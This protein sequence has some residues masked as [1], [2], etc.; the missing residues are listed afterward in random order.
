M[1]GWD[2]SPKLEIFVDKLPDHS[3]LRFECKDGLY[4]AEL[5]GYVNFIFKRDPEEADNGFGGAHQK[6]TMQDGTE[7]SFRGGWSSRAG[8]ANEL[9]FTE[10]MDVALTDEPEAWKKGYT[11]MSAH[12]TYEFAKN[13]VEK[14]CPNV[15][16]E[17]VRKGKG[18]PHTSDVQSDVVGHSQDDGEYIYVPRRVENPCET[19]KGAGKYKG[20]TSGDPVKTCNRC[21][22]TGK[23]LPKSRVFHRKNHSKLE[24]PLDIEEGLKWHF[25]GSPPK[26]FEEV[27]TVLSEDLEVIYRLTNHID[28]TWWEATFDV[29]LP[30]NS[31]RPAKDL[32]WVNHGYKEEPK[33][34]STSIGDVVI[35]ENGTVWQ[36]ASL[37]WDQVEV[38][39]DPVYMR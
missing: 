30:D 33:H 6:L 8:V 32:I 23:H 34:R 26:G 36:C 38:T 35:L 20:I 1:E 19:C 21:L 37:G 25:S 13:A 28:E 24:I 2:N 5:E 17:R 29:Q 27:A 15:W 22:G 16:L 10:C 7:L 39:K 11:F 9:G 14:F 3:E 31:L 4:Y 12:V 18:T